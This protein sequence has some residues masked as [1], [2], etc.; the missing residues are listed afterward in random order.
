MVNFS[1][2]VG[3]CY[4]HYIEEKGGTAGLYAGGIWE[5]PY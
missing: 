1:W 4:V 5:I 3:I 2:V